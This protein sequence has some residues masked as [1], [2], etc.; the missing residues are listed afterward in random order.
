[1][2]L[3]WAKTTKYIGHSGLTVSVVSNVKAFLD[4]R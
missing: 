3:I 2:V 4:D 1:M